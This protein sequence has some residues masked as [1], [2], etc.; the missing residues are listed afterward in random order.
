LLNSILQRLPKYIFTFQAAFAFNDA[1]MNEILVNIC[2]HSQLQQI[3]HSTK[4]NFS[5]IEKKVMLII[6]QMICVVVV[7]CCCGI[8]Y[9]RVGSE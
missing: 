7:V 4:R 5:T 8:G 3:D 1:K 9:T 2:F 6:L